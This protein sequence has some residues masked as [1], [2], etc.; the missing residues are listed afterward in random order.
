M[1][2]V[3]KLDHPNVVRAY[4]A[5]QIGGVL[6]IVMEYVKGQSLSVKLKSE[7]PLNPAEVVDCGA[8]AAL[9]LAHAHDLKIV[10]RDIKPSN[11]FLGKHRVIKVLD[12]GLG[13]LMEADAHATFETADGVAVGTVDYM[14]PEQA[15]GQE[16]DG[17]SDL[18][19]LGCAMYHLVTGRLPYQG[20]SPIERLG[21]RISNPPTPL[22]QVRP[23]LPPQFVRAMDKLLAV[24]PRE[25]FQSAKEAAEALQ[26]LLKKKPSSGG[27]A[28][29]P[30]ASPAAPASPEVG[31]EKA[32]DPAQAFLASLGPAGTPDAVQAPSPPR[33][34]IRD[35]TYPVWFKPLAKL[36]ERRPLV[37]LAAV[38]VLLALAA[39]AGY[40]IALV[41]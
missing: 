16:V 12:L 38:S 29:R 37:G 10:H 18:F 5:D 34:I 26:S 39:V 11:L 7:G 8:Q 22:L 21:K 35:P 28:R 6:Y 33:V 32:A 40:L 1:K 23:D 15:C 24:K 2:L 19:S 20:D 25:R 41:R 30:P 17:R 14:S 27:A 3:G 31:V 13:V 9:G 36:V 4:D